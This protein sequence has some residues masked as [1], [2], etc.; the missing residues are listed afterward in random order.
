MSERFYDLQF[1]RLESG[2]I[3]LRQS[4]FDEDNVIDCHPEQVSFIARRLCGMKPETSHQVAELERRLSVLTDRLQDVVC[5]DYFRGDV[6]ER[7]GDGLYMLA[8]LDAVVDL[9]LEFDGGRLEPEDS[10][11]RKPVVPPANAAPMPTEQAQ[12][13]N[14]SENEALPNSPPLEAQPAGGEQLGLAV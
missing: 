10:G 7:C 1:E 13:R 2:T 12:K 8:R 14:S 4:A 6:L 11:D 9:A 5:D 3:R